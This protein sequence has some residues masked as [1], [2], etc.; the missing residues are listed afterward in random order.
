MKAIEIFSVVSKLLWWQIRLDFAIDEKQ[1]FGF[2]NLFLDLFR[3]TVNIVKII[4]YIHPL[5]SNKH[6]STYNAFQTF[7]LSAQPLYNMVS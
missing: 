6:T 4:L 2:P 3:K 7:I 5:N 1:C